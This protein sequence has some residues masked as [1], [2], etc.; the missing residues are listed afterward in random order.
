ML[1]DELYKTG[2][3]A[4]IHNTLT[5]KPFVI[6]L[7][8]SLLVFLLSP[9]VY[10]S[11][12]GF[13]DPWYYPGYFTNFEHMVRQFGLTYYVSRLPYIL[14]GLFSYK[15]FSPEI[16]N[17]FIKISILF[18]CLY[19]L[20]GVVS[21]FYN[22]SIAL[23]TCL[24]FAFNTYATSAFAW[25]YPDGPAIAFTF[26]G[27]YFAL[28]PHK[29][30]P[31]KFQLILPG[32]CFAMAVYTNLLSALILFPGTIALLIFKN[33]TS[34]EKIYK[35]GITLFLGIGS[36][37]IIFALLSILFLGNHNFY[38][39]QFA[40]LIY[41]MSQKGYLAGMWGTGYSWIKEAFRLFGIFGLAGIGTWYILLNYSKA[42]EDAFLKFSYFFFLFSLILYC[43]A[44]FILNSL[45]L[46]VFYSSTYLVVPT[47]IFL[48]SLFGNIIKN[49]NQNDIK[50]LYLSLGF[51]AIIPAYLKFSVISS[52]T[53]KQIWEILGFL[54]VTILI[55]TI[56]DKKN[57][58]KAKNILLMAILFLINFSCAT[59]NN[60]SY[61]Y[62]KSNQTGYKIAMDIQNILKFSVPKDRDVRFW[63]GP[64]EPL[65]NFFHSLNSLYCW[66]WRDYSNEL[67][68]MSDP[69][70]KF[71][72]S[73]K[74]TI[75]NLVSN[76]NTLK[77]HHETLKK[78]GVKF[79]EIG[80]WEMVRDKS[81]F[82]LVLEDILENPLEKSK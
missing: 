23:I 22:R 39:P 60:I 28:I 81:V 14:Y 38:W 54:A 76:L 55:F 4:I 8:M 62:E 30:I 35:D 50:K 43:I 80:R 79:R 70:F 32:V 13:L 61:V 34:I 26:I 56:L 69:E 72:F 74:T 67:N 19:S 37:T 6:I 10:Y 41:T 59:D 1:K 49:Y 51:I 57:A 63:F 9:F 18:V 33:G 78:K 45:V 68:K 31:S 36:I 71:L 46:R 11:P 12:I 44:E 27:F 73:N 75:I 5:T 42:K 65:V 21:H 64:E 7:L 58:F 48:A 16:A 15:M 29:Q 40:Q 47:F 24:A 17:A 77:Q 53:Y 82:F 20:F 3:P 52:L 2:L 66:G 25:D